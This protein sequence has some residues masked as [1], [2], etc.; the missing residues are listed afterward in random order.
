MDGATPAVALGLQEASE[1]E[2]QEGDVELGGGLLPEMMMGRREGG[3]ALAMEG[4]S[5]GMVAGAMG[6]EARGVVSGAGGWR[7]GEGAG[8]RARR[9]AQG[10]AGSGTG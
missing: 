5:G 7:R 9:R 6:G 2:R 8:D 3:R 1:E 4:C 10:R